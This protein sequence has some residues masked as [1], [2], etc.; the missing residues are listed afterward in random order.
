MV[1]HVTKNLRALVSLGQPSEWDVLII[2]MLSAKLDGHTLSKWEE[3]RNNIDGDAPTLDQSYKFMIDHANVLESLNQ[4]AC[5]RNSSVTIIILNQIQI[6][7]KI[8][9]CF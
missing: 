7:I 5:S 2:F 3:H 8:V 6:R 4:S 9:C 1:D